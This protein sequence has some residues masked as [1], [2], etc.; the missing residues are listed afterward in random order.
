[1]IVVGAVLAIIYASVFAWRRRSNDA[2]KKSQRALDTEGVMLSR[3]NTMDMVNNPLHAGRGTSVIIVGAGG[4]VVDVNVRGPAARAASAGAPQYA[5]IA[6]PDHDYVEPNAG[7]PATYDIARSNLRSTPSYANPSFAYATAVPNPSRDAA[8]HAPAEESAYGAVV[9][10]SI[11]VPTPAVNRATPGS[12]TVAPAA[13]APAETHYSL[14]GGGGASTTTVYSLYQVL[15]TPNT[16]R[17]KDDQGYVMQ[18]N[19]AIIS[20]ASAGHIYAIPMAMDDSL[21]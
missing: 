19:H 13:A 20:Q 10:M 7:Q 4:S 15:A 17:A 9:D 6:D 11:T 2:K 5:V 8:D 3:T 21:V 1:M 18:P 16:Q 12:A 14:Y